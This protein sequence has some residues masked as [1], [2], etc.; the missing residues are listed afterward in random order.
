MIAE[1]I[2]VGTEILLGNIVNTNAEFLAKECAKLGLFVYHQ[3]TVGDNMERLTEVIKEAEKRADV[4]ILSGG[5]GPTMDDI[6]REG[7]AESLGKELVLDERILEKL[8]EFFESRGRTMPDNNVR[9]AMV[10]P[11]SIVVDNPNGTAPGMIVEKE[12]K[13]YMLLPGP[14]IEMKPMF[15]DVMAK[16]IVS[17]MKMTIYSKML[18]LCNVSES[19]VETQIKDLLDRQT[20]PTIAI[21][22]KI[23]VISIRISATAENEE[24]A[25]A[26]ISPIEKE[27]RERFGTL[28]FTDKEEEGLA[29]VVIGMLRDRR[30]TLAVAES[31]TGGMLSSN[32]VDESGV[33]DV[34]LEG[35]ITYSDRAKHEL[36][37]VRFERIEKYGAVSEEV[38]V[39]MVEGLIRVSG[40]AA[41][42][43]I[44]GIA[45]PAGGTKEKPVGL[46]YI[47]S[48][49]KG[50]LKVKKY[51]FRGSRD[52]IRSFASTYALILLR[53]QILEVDES[54]CKGK[55]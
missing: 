50:D 21:Y 34:F 44:T 30:K 25:K 32:I 38:A 23:G 40:A 5:L 9:Q 48:Y 20:N 28:V 37:G 45:G 41:G 42:I 53:E 49:Y 12:N 14:P 43:A 11:N 29:S 31:C 2:T 10:L 24:E 33:S 22:A 16:F 15:K 26:L 17:K 46:V 52:N 55:E 3:Q 6:T 4:I 27:L 1:I 7:L 54:F 39:D 47:S 8:R 19:L 35:L 18:K 13:I 51:K 36:L